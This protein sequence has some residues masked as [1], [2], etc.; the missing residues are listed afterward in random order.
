MFFLGLDIGTTRMKCGI[1]DD[2]GKLTYSDLCDYGTVS[3]SRETYID[4][5]T[6]FSRAV[7]MLKK[8]YAAQPFDSIAISSLGESFVLVDKDDKLL[9]SPMLYTD[10]R[11]EAEATAMEE[12]AHRIFSIAG[13]VPQ[14]MYSAYKLMWIKNNE[15]RVYEN[16]AKL[17]LVGEYMGYLLSG[18]RAIDYSLAA[19]TGVFDVHKCEFSEELCQLFGIDHSLFSPAVPSGSI[20]GQ[21]KDD[22]A[23]AIGATA[24]ITLIAGGHDQVCAAI[25]AGAVEAGVCADGM[26]T[27]ECLTAVYSTP[28]TDI[29][30][31]MC[32]YPNVP[33]GVN[34]LYC[35]YLLNYSCGSL[36]SWW[37]D[38]AYKGRGLSEKE[39]FAEAEKDFSDCPTGLLVL[40]YFAG[41]STPYQ[42]IN[43]KGGI[44]NLQ[45]SDSPS[46]VYQGILEGLC[47]EMRLNLELTGKNG[48]HPT[49]IIA[50]GG[51]SHS[52]KW[53]QIK[54]DV[55]G[56]P[57]YPLKV[58]E[59]GICG[60]AVMS[61]AA[62]L[63]ED[64]K[65]VA[66][67]FVKLDTPFEPRA[68]L[69]KKYD[70]EFAKYRQLYT[71]LKA[72]Y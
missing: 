43:A 49:R 26:G 57:V 14:G 70:G 55:L 72:F 40:P 39:L 48:I 62:L 34:G 10:P 68:E 16:A 30:M 13:V 47:M 35:T 42:N 59:A 23:T 38:T 28:M 44:L 8:A 3:R 51:G 27:V 2:S 61:A 11:G 19:R 60:C 18:I 25:G 54:A 63:G 21:V 7:N 32:G 69:T 52:G 64:I 45:L 36:V 15:P 12:H 17:M 4:T 53:L 24:P 46:K 33:H 71:T 65:A 29:D 67:R 37:L 56:I 5:E 58:K 6:I 1:Y 50:T 22:V 9:F 41:A 66:Q 20:I 31:G